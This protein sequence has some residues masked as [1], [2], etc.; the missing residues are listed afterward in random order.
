MRI[1]QTVRDRG[2]T[3]IELLVV[4]GIIALLIGMLMPA[5]G[6]AR[7]TAKSIQC[8][9]NL[10]Q[11]MTATLNYAIEY[12][13]V[14]PFTNSQGGTPLWGGPGW[15]Y[16]PDRF[17]AGDI[18]TADADDPDS[19]AVFEYAPDLR[20]YRC[21]MDS[22]PAKAQLT[23]APVRVFSSYVMN[24][25]M[26]GWNATLEKSGRPGLRLHEFKID[27]VCLWEADEDDPSLSDWNDGNNDPHDGM[28]DRHQ[29]G[30]SLAFLDGRVELMKIE[31]YQTYINGRTRAVEGG[32]DDDDEPNIF[33]CNPMTKDG[34]EAVDPET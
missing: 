15:L 23:E 1:Q 3:L 14:L 31:E 4:I 18:N 11:L 5:L 26:N 17:T 13:D 20:L 29:M 12:D 9:N 32:A 6:S 30:S 2:F 25:A 7:D 21:A 8:R 27:G 16:H 10:K 22:P 33:Y 19:G 34:G 28:S 24:R